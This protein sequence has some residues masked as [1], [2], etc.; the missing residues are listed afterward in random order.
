MNQ[1]LSTREKKVL[2]ERSASMAL[3][4]LP[5]VD[6]NLPNP[7]HD[8][9]AAIEDAGDSS[10]NE[11]PVSDSD[12]WFASKVC[13]R[14]ICEKLLHVVS[15]TP[16]C[17]PNSAYRVILLLQDQGSINAGCSNKA[18]L[19]RAGD[20]EENP[21]PN[22]PKQSNKAIAQANVRRKP[23]PKQPAPRAEQAV[24][25]ELAAMMRVAK[26]QAARNHVEVPKVRRPRDMLQEHEKEL[27]DEYVMAMVAPDPTT[28]PVRWGGSFAK[29]LTALAAPLTRYEADWNT[30]DTEAKQLTGFAFREP[31]R[32]TVI[33]NRNANGL[34]YSYRA[35]G[36]SVSD[37]GGVRTINTLPAQGFNLTFEA[38][39][40]PVPG[41]EFELNPVFWRATSSFRP[42][43]DV[44][45]SGTPN[46]NA[47]E[48]RFVYLE[49]GTVVS[50][51][52]TFAAT[53]TAS[54]MLVAD[55]LVGDTIELNVGA[56]PPINAANITTPQTITI[57]RSGYYAFRTVWRAGILDPIAGVLTCAQNLTFSHNGPVF[58]HRP[59][60]GLDRNFAS[61]SAI[62]ILGHS[63]MYTN[64]ASPLY[65]QGQI[66]GLQLNLG[67]S[68]LD[69][70]TFDAVSKPSTNFGVAGSTNQVTVLPAENG[71]YISSRP[72]QPEDLDMLDYFQVAGI[73]L[74][75]SYYPIIPKSGYLVVSVEV[76]TRE[77]RDGYW[78]VCTSLE[79]ET[80][81]P[82]RVVAKSTTP[83]YIVDAAL[84]MVAEVPQVCE[85]PS[86]MY[87]IYNTL[88]RGLAKG[89]KMAERYGPDALRYAKMAQAVL[90]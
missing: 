38:T 73:E 11:D 88:K 13:S 15:G 55:L 24:S 53:S 57:P 14:I 36:L 67:T 81:D 83:Q 58:A 33:P 25:K 18:L 62:R 47:E 29:N 40:E 50:T 78:S 82:W 3:Q 86:H 56:T 76:A 26:S 44:L 17:V 89:I 66:A 19:L 22:G 8:T 80:L 42:H 23:L 31:L 61:A 48:R 84:D 43:G 49:L 74:Q 79:Y 37:P 9:G 46:G 68:W 77:G 51:Q 72:T 32:H 70:T 59:I 34:T 21:G 90:A 52:M 41:Q 1:L 4:N 64:K 85:N 87:K 10:C 27:A 7:I 5:I 28:P 39:D 69:Y 30:T 16:V 6:R 71:M 20:V 54:F 2:A 12:V 45:F 60:P 65:R 35:W 75:D 63:L